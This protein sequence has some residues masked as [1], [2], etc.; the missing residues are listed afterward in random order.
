VFTGLVSA[1]GRVA[2]IRRDGETLELT[3]EAPYRDITAGE[4]IA[5]DGAC[6]TAVDPGAGRFRVQ[7]VGTTAARTLLASL[8]AGDRVNLERAVRAGDPLGGHLVQGHVDGVAQVVA[9]TDSVLN[10]R[11]PREVAEVTVL[12]GSITVNGVSLTVNEVPEPGV[13]QISLIPH[14]LAQ[15]TLGAL[16]AGDRV[17]VEGDVIGKY[18]R[19]LM[20]GRRGEG[21][22]GGEGRQRR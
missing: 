10:L 19:A 12:H 11:V 13:V 18:V 6:L 17:H 22:A 16:K 8:A 15:T 14:T 2:G 4:S 21:G 1:V 5:I 7:V 20:G 9:R 3:I